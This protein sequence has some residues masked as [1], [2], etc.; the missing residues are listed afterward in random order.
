L[1]SMAVADALLDERR[2]RNQIALVRG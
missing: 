1:P 2:I